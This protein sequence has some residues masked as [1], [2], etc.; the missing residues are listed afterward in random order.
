MKKILEMQKKKVIAGIDKL[1]EKILSCANDKAKQEDLI[2]EFCF[3]ACLVHVSI[4]P[5]LLSYITLDRIKK[6]L[7]MLKPKLGFRF[8]KS[9]IYEFELKKSEKNCI[10]V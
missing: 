7:K 5:S 3:L 1:C 6:C 2:E 8:K 9:D 4:D 10:L